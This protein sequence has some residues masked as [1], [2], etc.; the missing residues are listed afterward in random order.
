MAESPV[1]IILA[2]GASSRMWPLRE[3]S[4]IKFGAQPLLVTQLQQYAA[5]GFREVIIVANLE[6]RVDIAGLVE[7]MTDMKIE[8]VVQPEPKGMGDA[9]LKAEPVLAN[10]LDT[11][12]YI[13]QIHDV[14]EDKLHL[15]MLAAHARN[16][17]ASYLAGYEM[18]EYFPGGYLVVDAAG[19][20]SG[21]VEKPGA[22]N[23]PSNLVTFVAHLHTNVGQLFEAI[24]AEYTKD[25]PSD[26]HYER[27][28]DALMK[29]M[30]YQVVRYS[31]QWKALKF[32]WHVLDIMNVFLDQLKGKGQ[33]VAES[34]FVAKTAS[35]VGDVYI[36]EGAKIFPGAAVV[37]PAYIGAGVIV[38]N[39]ALVRNSM[40]LSGSNV[41]FTTEVARSYVAEHVDMHACRVLDSVLASGVNFSAGCTTANL[42]IDKGTV[43]SRVKGNKLDTGRDKLGAIIGQG[44]FIA[45]D[46]MTMP[47]VKIGEGAQ[48]GPGTHVIQ[49]VGDGK[50]VYVKQEVVVS[51]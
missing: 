45:V 20:I 44:A 14:V 32:P 4:L 2:G 9:I 50:R 28:M 24:K 8:I 31:G 27:A 5:L 36:G 17:A 41:G 48:I 23:R 37:G 26:D 38:G 25:I 35:L 18:T 13:N 46:A 12:V 49:D 40:V 43:S 15:D 19:R 21:M 1:L 16:P 11:P 51:D 7:G 22:E 33:Q 10:R 30:T 3:K 42:R 47:G 39:N 34:A 6:N 29:G